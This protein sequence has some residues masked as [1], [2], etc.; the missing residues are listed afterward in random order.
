MYV[1][2]KDKVKDLIFNLDGE[3]Q[4]VRFAPEKIESSTTAI[5]EIEPDK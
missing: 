3:K 2:F 4:A 5:K 1:G